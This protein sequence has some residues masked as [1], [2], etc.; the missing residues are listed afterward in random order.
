MRQFQE[1]ARTRTCSEARSAL[2]HEKSYPRVGFSPFFYAH[3]K[4]QPSFPVAF[5]CFFGSRK[6]L[7][8][9]VGRVRF[10]VKL[11]FFGAGGLLA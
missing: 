11:T 10:L 6:G 5:V 9:V 2:L 3:Q 8:F 7:L 4:S 1:T